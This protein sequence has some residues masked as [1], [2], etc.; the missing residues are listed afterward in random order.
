MCINYD[1]SLFREMHKISNL[2]LSKSIDKQPKSLFK[3]DWQERIHIA[4]HK[5]L[6]KKAK[7]PKSNI[8]RKERNNSLSLFDGSF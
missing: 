3:N 5:I 8:R 1:I 2:V 4:L 7:N 6:L